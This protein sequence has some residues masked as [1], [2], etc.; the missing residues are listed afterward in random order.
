MN[1]SDRCLRGVKVV[2]LGFGMAT[3]LVARFLCDEG[4]EVIRVETIGEDPFYSVYPAYALWRRGAVIDRDSATSPDRLQSLLDDADICIIGGEDFPGLTRK[5]DAASLQTHHARLIILNIEGYPIGS[6]HAGRP[7]TDL[8]VQARSG[9]TFEHY[10]DRPILMSFEPCSYGAALHG[11]AGVMAAL[12][13]RESTGRGQRVNTSLYEGALSWPLVLWFQTSIQT[14][15]STFVLPKNPYP[16]IFQCEDGVWI[17]I[18]IGSAG[19]KGRLY[20]I[21]QINDPTVGINDSGMVSATTDTKNFFGD[22]ELLSDHI[23]NLRSD[24][25]LKQIWAAGLAAELVL[26]PGGCWNDRQV[27]HNAIIVNGAH[28]DRYVGRP[29]QINSSAAPREVVVRGASLPL[30]GI[31]VVDFGTFISGPYSATLLAD[32]GAEVTKVEPLSGDPTRALFRAFAAVNRGKEAITIDMKTPEGV[33]IAQDLCLAADVVTSN[34]RP[35]VSSRLGID[36]ATLHQRKP[37]LIVL[38]ISS[39]GS[40]GPRADGAGFDM[41]F[42]AL[43]G[44]GWRGGGIGNAPLWNR[45]TMTDFTAAMLGGI[46]VLMALFRRRREGSGADIG[47][48]LLNAGLYLLSDLIMHADGSFDGLAQLNHAQTAYHPAEGLYEAA[49]GWLA[50]AAR[51]EGA[52]RRLVEALDLGGSITMPRDKW[53]ADTHGFLATAIRGRSVAELQVQLEQAGVWVERCCTD[54]ERASLQDPR[55]E[56]LGIVYTTQH[57]KFGEVRQIGPLVRLSGAGAVAQRPAP[58]LGEHTDAILAGLALSAADIKDLH[59]RAVVR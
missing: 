39:Y 31:K 21:L 26:E 3:A 57:P 41:C 38:E 8:L 42:Q 36:A 23:K 54:G 55:L 10:T 5:Y 16:L 17:Q 11:L 28:G 27:L 56:S 46:A 53:S 24:D 58:R 15:A 12:V 40:T 50:V 4:A 9:L 48:N 47:I 2:D 30:T 35:G 59:D 52:A 14:P 19:S 6:P 18:V 37:E 34:F 45:T 33:K 51:D 32:L 20:Q 1:A 44:H 13:Q 49:D 7:A 25:L 29:L 43:C 22:V